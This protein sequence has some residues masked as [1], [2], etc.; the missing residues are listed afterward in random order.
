MSEA[1]ARRGAR[2]RRAIRPSIDGRRAKLRVVGVARLARVRVGLRAAHGPARPAALRRSSGWTR[3]RSPRPRASPAP[4]TT[5]RS[6]SPPADERETIRRVD[7]RAR[8]VR[9]ARR[10]R[11]RR[12]AVGEARRPED[13]PAREARE[14]AC[15]SSSS[16]SPRSCSTSCSRASSG[17]QR[18]QIATLKALGYRTRE[19]LR[20]YLELALAIC[21]LGAARRRRARRARRREPPRRVRAVLP[22]PGVPLPVRRAGRSSARR[23]SP[24][25]PGSRGTY[26]SP[27][28]GPSRFRPPRRCGR[29]R[30]PAT[31]GRSSIASTRRL[32]RPSSGWS[33]ATR[34][35]A[36]SG[37]C[38]RPDRSR[39]R[40]PSSSPAA[41]S[42]TRSTRSLRL[43]FEVVAP[44][45]HH[46]DAR[47][48]RAAG[49]RSRGRA[50]PR[51][52]PTP[53]ASAWCRCGSAPATASGRPRSS[54]SRPDVDLQRLLDAEQRP[55]RAPARGPRPVARP[56]RVARRPRRRRDR[57]RGARGGPAPASRRGR[58]LVDDLLGL[59]GYMDARELARLLDE[60]PRVNVVLARGRAR[61]TSTRSSTG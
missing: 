13:R 26:S 39:S 51:R 46:G 44:R 43:Q 36:R 2:A 27:C 24:S 42:A 20:H 25:P 53:R 32:R 37:S 9:R 22:V 54:A 61:A 7:A 23:S 18:E 45:G 48:A 34:S 30:R 6:S 49:R 11:P 28:G 33:S 17:T 19:L 57:R 10:G 4:S 41:S 8:A 55:L 47:S 12:S 52:R 60:A 5:S 14:D 35:A 40:P 3:T 31:I 59:S 58:G 56:R 50:H 38:S 21:V 1:F 16:A 29:R 15:R